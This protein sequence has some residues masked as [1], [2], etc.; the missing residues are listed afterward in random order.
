MIELARALSADVHAQQRDKLGLPYAAHPARVARNVQSHPAYA[1]L[2]VDDQSALV[3]AGY[4]HDVVEDGP[5]YGFDITPENL[6]ERGFSPTTVDIVTLVTK[7]ADTED[8]DLPVVKDGDC[9]S[10]CRECI[11]QLLPRIAARLGVD[12]RGLG[13]ETLL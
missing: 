4:L 9:V 5:D 6:L 8:L 1:A 3:C 10:C 13:G 12:P 11:R 2:P 7:P